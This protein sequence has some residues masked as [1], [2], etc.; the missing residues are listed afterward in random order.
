MF[1]RDQYKRRSKKE[2]L[3]DYQKNVNGEYIYNGLKYD[4]VNKKG[5]SKKQWII[6][7][8]VLNII[9]FVVML[10]PGFILVPGMNNCWYVLLP[11][12]A[13]LIMTGY[14]IVEIIRLAWTKEQIKAWDY[15]K[16]AARLPKLIVFTLIVLPISLIGE[17]IYIITNGAGGMIAGIIVFYACHIIAACAAAFMRRIT[18]EVTWKIVTD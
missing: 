8:A 7:L 13:G 5:R 17:L 9:A 14:L 6:E 2:Y 4:Y 12:G 15:D 1:E 11:Y 16:V 18:A 10:V 3:N